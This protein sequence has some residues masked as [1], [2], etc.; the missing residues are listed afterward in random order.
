MCTHEVRNC[1]RC[2]QAFE[3]K[4]GTI[5][6]CQCYAVALSLEQRVFIESR[7]EDCLCAACLRTLAVSYQHFREKYVFGGSPSAEDVISP[8]LPA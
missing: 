8:K 5:T 7:Y 6:Q 2:S 4:A 1:P 3:C